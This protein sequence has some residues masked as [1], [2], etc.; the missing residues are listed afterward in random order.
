MK[1]ILKLVLYGN[2]YIKK[3]SQR[4]IWHKYLKRTMVVYSANYS[5][6]R[7]DTLLQLGLCKNGYLQKKIKKPIDFP[8][9]MEAHFY[10]KDTRLVKLSNCYETI[11]DI[12]I[13]AKILKNSTS[14]IITNY[15][16]SKIF[17]DCK[18]PKI[19]IWILKK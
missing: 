12:L 14:N 2:P 18:S 5:A 13:E 4:V 10:L 15:N 19:K 3:N 7:K 16:N 8:I 1:E 17:Y 6:W 11:E 9:I